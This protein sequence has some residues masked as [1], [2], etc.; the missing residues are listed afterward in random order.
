MSNAF[1]FALIFGMNNDVFAQGY[2]KG[3]G[4]CIDLRDDA[5]D[6]DGDGIPNG[7]DDDYVPPK[8]GTGRK[9]QKGKGRRA[10]RPNVENG[11]RVRQNDCVPARDGTG[12]KYRKVKANRSTSSA[13]FLRTRQGRQAFR[14]EVGFSYWERMRAN[15]VGHRCAAPSWSGQYSRRAFTGRQMRLR[16]GRG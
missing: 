5:P 16:R 12:N 6:D 3:A 2:R 13:P 4:I 14:G 10:N 7:Q 15:N 8:D 11:N 1:V 9:Y